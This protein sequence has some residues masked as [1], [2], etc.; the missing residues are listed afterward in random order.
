M[1]IHTCLHTQKTTLNASITHTFTLGNAHFNTQESRFVTCCTYSWIMVYV[2]MSHVSFFDRCWS[3]GHTHTPNA[4]HHTRTLSLTLSPSFSLPLSL[5]HKHTD[6]GEGVQER[7]H[8]ASPDC[9]IQNNHDA[10]AASRIEAADCSIEGIAPPDC[11]IPRKSMIT[12]MGFNIIIMIMTYRV[13]GCRRCKRCLNLQ[14][15]IRKRATNF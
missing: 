11:S 8:V 14:I 1:Y 3:R 12:I 13:T 10:G 4:H 15:F 6:I 2:W 7:R 5:S 9:H